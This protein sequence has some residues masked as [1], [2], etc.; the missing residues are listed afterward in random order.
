MPW[1]WRL[2]SC[3]SSSC[4]LPEM[5]SHCPLPR[6]LAS[7]V[8]SG[9]PH[10][11]STPW[12]LPF[13]FPGKGL[14]MILKGSRLGTHSTMACADI[15]SWFTNFL[16]TPTQELRVLWHKGLKILGEHLSTMSW[17]NRPW[18]EE[19]IGSTSP[20]PLLIRASCGNSTLIEGKN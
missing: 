10:S 18:I 3:S 17:S 6:P 9:L 8:L 1:V 4:H 5:G 15:E 19:T 12:L 20:N 2:S 16:A 13:S 7:W 14:G 11:T